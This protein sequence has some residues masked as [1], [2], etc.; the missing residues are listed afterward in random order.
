V[1][2]AV[3]VLFP[4]LF[5]IAIAFSNW[6]LANLRNPSFG[7]EYG[8][9]N[10]TRVFSDL[11]NTPIRPSTVHPHLLWT[12]INLFSRARRLGGCCSTGHWNAVYRTPLI[13]RGDPAGDCGWPGAASQSTIRLC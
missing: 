9:A 8:V 13:I 11:L 6:R 12:F 2:L 1:G 7:L 4:F 3:F 5:N 10:I